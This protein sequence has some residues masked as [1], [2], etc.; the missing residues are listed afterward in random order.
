[1]Q[2][3]Q[4]HIKHSHPS[5]AKREACVKTIEQRS[6]EAT[7]S[8]DA[9]SLPRGVAPA[10]FKVALAWTLLPSIYRPRVL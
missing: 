5:G 7:V 4:T 3:N 2:E 8:S 6:G 10:A 9:A 1:M